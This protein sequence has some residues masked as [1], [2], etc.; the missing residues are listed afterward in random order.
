MLERKEKRGKD[1]EEYRVHTK[2]LTTNRASPQRQCNRASFHSP[3]YIAS[4]T[5]GYGHSVR[6]LLA[7]LH[8]SL[9]P[10]HIICLTQ[11]ESAS[12]CASAS[13]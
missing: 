8:Y 3:G 6:F 13:W 2:S 7:C 12:L 9:R 10:L 11:S 4:S 5:I 1:D